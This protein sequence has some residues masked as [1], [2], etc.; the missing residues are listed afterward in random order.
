[1]SALSRFKPKIS[2]EFSVLGRCLRGFRGSQFDLPKC[3][4]AAENEAGEEDR[5]VRDDEDFHFSHSM[6]FHVS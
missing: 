3:H 6:K 4:P 5:C 1:M 2:P